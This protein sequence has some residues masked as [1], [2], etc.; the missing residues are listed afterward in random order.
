MALA[1]AERGEGFL[2]FIAIC[3]QPY[4]KI[5]H[6]FADV[7]FF[8]FYKSTSI[9]RLNHHNRRLS[10]VRSITPQWIFPVAF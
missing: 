7:S 3:S 1:A 9:L 4:H 8:Y 2:G 10:N 5:L 6:T